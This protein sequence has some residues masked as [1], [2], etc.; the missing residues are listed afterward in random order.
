MEMS[1]YLEVFIEESKEHLQ[2]C[3]DHLL[4]LEK[5]PN[6]MRII[7]EIFRSAHTLKGMS[8]TMGYEDIADL[9]HMMENV[10]DAIRN[11]K[12]PVT[13]EIFDVVLQAVDYLEEMVMNIA[14]G[15]TGKKDVR[16][17]VESLN[18][19]EAGGAAITA[20]VVETVA[21]TVLEG[22]NQKVALQYDDYEITVISQSFEQDFNAFEVTVHL[23]EDC[24]LKAARVF[25]V[26]GIFEKS[27][28]IVKSEPKVEQ[29][30]NEDFG[31]TFSVALI[32]KE[33]ADTLRDKVMKVSEVESVTVTVL[34][35]DYLV[36]GKRAKDDE[37]V[38][39]L[40]IA[41]VTQ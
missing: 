22:N 2:S 13:T 16:E 15:G 25:M 7:S 28:E 9:T 20:A 31:E 32:T 40:E 39:T 24:V 17:L 19:I 14:S 37:A 30:E 10:L 18:R 27:G 6:D 11:S 36:N 21:T 26:F 1:Q 4:E 29:L 34:T 3:N 12:I 35:N 8:A 38:K 41:K 5:N 23:R 33:D